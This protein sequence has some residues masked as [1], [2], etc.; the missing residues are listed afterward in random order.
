MKPTL[1]RYVLIFYKLLSQESSMVITQ[2]APEVENEQAPLHLPVESVPKLPRSAART[3]T[4]PH[5]PIDVVTLDPQ[6]LTSP[7]GPETAFS[8]A[9]RVRDIFVPKA[10][11]NLVPYFWNKVK[12]K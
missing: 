12:W 4:R 10:L 8:S 9:K 5:K 7:D 3:A 2:E 6:P 1:C 11:L